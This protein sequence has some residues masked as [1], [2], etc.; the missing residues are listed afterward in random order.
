MTRTPLLC[1]LNEARCSDAANVDLIMP[2]VY[3]TPEVVLR[4]PWSY[5]VD[6]GIRDDGPCLWPLHLLS[7]R[8]ELTTPGNCFGT[9]SSPNASPR[10][11][12]TTTRT[13]RACTSRRWWPSWNRLRWN[14]TMLGEEPTLLGRRR[15]VPC[16]IPCSP[17]FSTH[18][19]I[20]NTVSRQ[21]D[22][23]RP[24]PRN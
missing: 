8:A 11:A 10:H 2:N 1:D 21:M 19:L 7:S 18:A 6:F 4:M 15:W 3:W 9:S 23:R 13:R 20:K 17:T 22:K 12:T 14:Y 5:P 24:H 16:G